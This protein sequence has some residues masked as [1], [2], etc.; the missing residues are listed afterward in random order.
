MLRVAKVAE[1]LRVAHVAV[2]LHVAKV[3]EVP[4]VAQVA[5]VPR[6]AMVAGASPGAGPRFPLGTAL[7]RAAP[8]CVRRPRVR[9]RVP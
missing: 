7:A 1:V 3:A 5:A 9:R 6:V 4:R 2:V 8:V